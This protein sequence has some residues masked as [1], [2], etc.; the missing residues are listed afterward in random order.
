MQLNGLFCPGTG[1]EALSPTKINLSLLRSLKSFPFLLE[2]FH[3]LLSTYVR[4]DVD[5]WRGLAGQ[6]D[7]LPGVERPY[8]HL[9]GLLHCPERRGRRRVVAVLHRLQ[10]A[11]DLFGYPARLKREWMERYT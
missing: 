1:E 2:H 8:D 11:E 9:A 6:A 4:V 5:L 10:L 7:E 3:F